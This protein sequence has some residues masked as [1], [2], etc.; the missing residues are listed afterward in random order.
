MEKEFN[1]LAAAMNYWESKRYILS[2]ND[3]GLIGVG[4]ESILAAVLDEKDSAQLKFEV[5]LDP[6]IVVVVRDG[7]PINQYN[8]IKL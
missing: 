4:R 6:P 1:T 2:P 7:V 3:E 8:L 5:S